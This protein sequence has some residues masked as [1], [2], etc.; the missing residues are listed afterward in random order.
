M[1]EV[2]VFTKV[3]ERG[4][5]KRGLVRRLPA[6]VVEELYVA[7]LNDT[8]EKLRDYFPFVAY[9]PQEKLQIL[10][11]LLGDRK[12]IMQRGRDLGER[13]VNLFSDFYKMGI[14]DT[15]MVGCDVPTLRKEHVDEAFKLMASNDVVL[16]PANDG[17]F[18]LI[19]GGGLRRELFEGV[20]WKTPDVLKKTVENAGKL[21]LK[22]AF[23]QTLRDV[24]NPQDLDAVWDSGELDEKSH[25]YRVMEQIRGLKKQ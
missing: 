8:L 1:R 17:G 5:V 9:Y 19:G 21:G 23:T 6:Q 14:R 18:Y 25:T 13:I 7:F 3:P 4:Y 15:L 12:Y 2:L 10:W 22:V 11:Y 20:V 16:G 24:D